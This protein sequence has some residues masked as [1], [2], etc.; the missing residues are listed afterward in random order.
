MIST[1]LAEYVKKDSYRGHSK[2]NHYHVP[3]KIVVLVND[4]SIDRDAGVLVNGFPIKDSI[5]IETYNYKQDF[6]WRYTYYNV[7]EAKK[8]LKN[9][10]KEGS[11]NI[12]LLSK[13][14]NRG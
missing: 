1:T 13:Y 4:L 6:L 3:C 14:S 9:L 8:A 5:H 11:F 10:L 7:D 12:K 2:I